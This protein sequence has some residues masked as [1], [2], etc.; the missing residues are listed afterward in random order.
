MNSLLQKER[1][2]SIEIGR[3]KS[4]ENCKYIRKVLIVLIR[5]SAAVPEAFL[6]SDFY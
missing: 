1:E 6:L 2:M 4:V 5:K 3:G